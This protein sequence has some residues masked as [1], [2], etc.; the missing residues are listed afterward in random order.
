MLTNYL[1]ACDEPTRCEQCWNRAQ[2]AI[3]HLAA[4]RDGYKARDKLRGEAAT[5]V[6]EG[7]HLSR[8]LGMC[9]VHDD[10][11]VCWWYDRISALRAAI[12][13]TPEE[14]KE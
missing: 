4:Q 10:V 8:E 11:D 9:D 13:V 3:E 1:H 2:D 6:L 14:A 7:E 12:D 5:R